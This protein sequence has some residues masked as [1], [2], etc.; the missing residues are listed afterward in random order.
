MTAS[1]PGARCSNR[2][3]AECVLCPG[4]TFE[5]YV[6]DDVLGAGGSATVY[7][8]HPVDG[9]QAVALKVLAN[10]HRGP[11]E[12]MRL[13][14]EFEFAQ[15]LRHPHV[16]SVYRRG[17]GWL[18]MELIIGGTAAALDQ[19]DDRLTA[20]A[21]IADALDYAH[22]RG[23]VH[24]DVKPTNV[25]VHEDF[26]DGG[27][28]LTDF[29]VAYAV[30]E[31]NRRQPQPLVASLPYLA[32]E[33]LHGRA[34]AAATDEYALACTTV[35]LVT[36]SPPF[37]GSTPAEVA[38]AQLYSPPPYLSRTFTWLPRGFDGVIGKA[39]AKDPELRYPT[40]AEFAAAVLRV[41]RR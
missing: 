17:D 4:Q 16:V 9:R 30:S 40:C 28:V 2:F 35:E 29:G 31:D 25:L 33:M 39:M 18:A 7:R 14:R 23:I 36:G 21:Q 8:A 19:L 12:S 15:R 32:P 24:C 13:Q 41:F 6:I 5:G 10:D 38:D 11:A 26:S 37:V 22:W 34:P 20:V 27:A 1:Y 3:Y